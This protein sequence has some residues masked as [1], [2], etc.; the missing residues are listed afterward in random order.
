MFFFLFDLIAQ[1]GDN[2]IQL[3]LF[4]RFLDFNLHDFPFQIFLFFLVS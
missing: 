4:L 2:H 1:L 3:F